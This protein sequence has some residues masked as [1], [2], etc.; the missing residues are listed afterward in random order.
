M[1]MYVLLLNLQSIAQPADRFDHILSS[2]KCTMHFKDEDMCYTNVVCYNHI[3]TF[4]AGKTGKFRRRVFT[5]RCIL[6]GL[7]V[8]VR[9]WLF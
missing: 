8:Y 9:T 5:V 3:L 6:L 4:N 7:A 2:M 1:Y